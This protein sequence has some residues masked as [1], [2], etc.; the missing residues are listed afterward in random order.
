MVVY[1]SSAPSLLIF[2]ELSDRSFIAFGQEIR[3]EQ[4]PFRAAL[5]VNWNPMGDSCNP[6]NAL[7]L[8]YNWHQ[9]HPLP[10]HIKFG[11]FLLFYLSRTQYQLNIF[12]IYVW[13]LYFTSTWRAWSIQRG[14]VKVNLKIF[15]AKELIS[16]RL[17]LT[18]IQGL[19]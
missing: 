8:A 6:M 13:H 4:V 19:K 17:H 9:Q 10:P 18:I 5:Y 3:G 12:K 2:R 16:S 15:I 14:R 11:S 7:N 1:P